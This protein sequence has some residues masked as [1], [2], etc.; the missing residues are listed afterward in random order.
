MP[1]GM[2]VGFGPDHTV[3]D[4]DP[5]P[6]ES[7]HSPPIFGPHLLWPRPH[8]ARRGPSS[9]KKGPKRRPSQLLLSTCFNMEPRLKWS[10]IILAAKTILFHLRRGS[11]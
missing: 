10:K 4:G 9:P 8:C 6:Q 11:K 5:T 1:L 7:G 3:L 2:E